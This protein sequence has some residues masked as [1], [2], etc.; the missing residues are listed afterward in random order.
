MK[1]DNKNIDG[2]EEK[3]TDEEIL[4]DND[5]R[6]SNKKS[7][8]SNPLDKFLS[9]LNL[10][11]K[12]DSDL[13]STGD[14]EEFKRI[15]AKE[16]SLDNFEN[17]ESESTDDVDEVNPLNTDFLG[18]EVK[19]HYE[20]DE[21]NLE[22]RLEYDVQDLD[23]EDFSTEPEDIELDTKAVEL[24]ND[25]V[26]CEKDL[27]DEIDV[28]DKEEEALINTSKNGKDGSL[29]DAMGDVYKE[30][31]EESPENTVNTVNKNQEFAPDEDVKKSDPDEKLHDILGIK[32]KKS[33][34]IM[35]SNQ[36]K[37]VESLQ[38]TDKKEISPEPISENQKPQNYETVNK[39][40][41]KEEK[42]IDDSK[43]YVFS[44]Q[45]NFEEKSKVK[46]DIDV[47]GGN[48]IDYNKMV[49]DNT[50][51]SIDSIYSHKELAKEI[52]E[53]VFMIERYSKTLPENLPIDV[54]RQSVL[55]I[56][57]ATSLDVNELIDD[58]Y[59][60]IDVL[61]EVMDDIALTADDLKDDNEQEIIELEEK[62]KALKMDIQKRKQYQKTQNTMIGYEIQ[63]IV[64]IIEFISKE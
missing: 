55:N 7:N 29:H 18:R 38:E 4:L 41:N 13:L 57:K 6:N 61:N 59:S 2:I 21:E 50:L 15:L 49:R 54:K 45:V 64:N 42:E 9:S 40:E 36:D 16:P 10:N 44:E 63:R 8:F 56:L 1:D 24:E 27:N 30:V 52:K 37:I 23:K 60:R 19:E 39:V 12:K 51:M 35:P 14:S 26:V 11:R 22:L 47:L 20:I 5:L 34:T 33:K 48:K 43:E 32:V 25:T 17:D 53:T 58:A 3:N 46:Y 62:I 31:K 28:L